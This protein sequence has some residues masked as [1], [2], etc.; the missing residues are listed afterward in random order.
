MPPLP[1]SAV[2]GATAL[3][4]QWLNV[5]LFNPSGVDEWVRF[6]RRFRYA[7]PTVIH[8]LPRWGSIYHMVAWYAEENNTYL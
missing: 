4:L 5:G 1:F 6:F 3:P 2:G 8:I 7:P